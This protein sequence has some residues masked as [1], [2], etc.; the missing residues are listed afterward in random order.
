MQFLNGITLLLVYQLVG[1]LQS[2]CWACLFPG[3]CLAW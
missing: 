1:R 3:R 2:D